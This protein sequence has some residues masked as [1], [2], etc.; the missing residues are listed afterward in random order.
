MLIVAFVYMQ[1]MGERVEEK[2]T[3]WVTVINLFQRRP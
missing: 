1:L 3:D 2:A